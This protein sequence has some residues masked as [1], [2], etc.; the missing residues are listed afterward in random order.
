M[1]DTSASESHDGDTELPHREHLH[2]GARQIPKFRNS[3]STLAFISRLTPRPQVDGPGATLL[4][5]GR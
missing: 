2:R 5:T 3:V 4:S 1:V